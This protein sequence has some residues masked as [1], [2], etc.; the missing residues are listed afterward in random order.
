[1]HST[2]HQLLGGA[3]ARLYVN[4]QW[5]N[6]P[7]FSLKEFFHPIMDRIYFEQPPSLIDADPTSIASRVVGGVLLCGM[8]NNLRISRFL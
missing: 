2:E 3:L 7:N 4:H 5:R 1:M 8:N 6:D